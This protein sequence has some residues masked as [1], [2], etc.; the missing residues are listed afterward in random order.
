[1]ESFEERFARIEQRLAVVEERVAAERVED[2]PARE[3]ERTRQGELAALVDLKSRVDPPGG[4][5]YAGWIERGGQPLQWQFGH[6]LTDLEDHDWASLAERFDALGNP[7]RL[8]LLQ[9][10]WAGHETVADLT[11]QEG[12]GTTGQV[13]HHLNA[14][15]AVG[16]LIQSTRGRYTVPADRVVP[17]LVILSA[18]RGVA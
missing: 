7:V 14:L 15:V 8:K 17:L 12:I 1:M 5:T 2:R 16:W 18:A 11:G 6:T 9:L 10:V 4:V 3:E 13:Y